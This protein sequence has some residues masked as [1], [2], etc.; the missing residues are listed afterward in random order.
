MN[1]KTPRK[2]AVLRAVIRKYMDLYSVD[3]EELA[4][5]VCVSRRTL[6][7]RLAAPDSFRL[8]EL[9]AIKKR[10]QIPAEELKEALL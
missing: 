9:R 8:D 5:A 7:S 4:K 1:H 10:L 6:F 2:D 3:A